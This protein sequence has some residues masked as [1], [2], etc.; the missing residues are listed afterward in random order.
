MSNLTGE[1]TDKFS[2]VVGG[3]FHASLRRLG[4]IGTDGLPMP[5]AAVSLASLAMR[6]RPGNCCLRLIMSLHR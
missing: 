2:L 4:L 1:G 3:P 5:L 6:P